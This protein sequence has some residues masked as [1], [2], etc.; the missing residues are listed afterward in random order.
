MKQLH[1][2]IQGRFVVAPFRIFGRG[3]LV[4][5]LGASLLTP[6]AMPVHAAD[7]PDTI[8][9]WLNDINGAQAMGW[10]KAQNARTLDLLGHGPLYKGLYDTSL[11]L[12]Q[13]HDR[14]AMPMQMDGMVYNFWRDEHH[15]RGILRRTTADSFATDH[16][17]WTVALDL[18]ALAAKEKRNWV[19]K[20]I[21][22][23]HSQQNLCLL[24]LSDG[25]E[26][27]STVREF[28]LRTGQFVEGGF[29]LPHAKQDS[30]WLDRDSLLVSYPWSADDLTESSYPYIVK[31][32]KRGQS[33]DQAQTV[34]AG[35]RKDVEVGPEVL[36]DGAGHQ[37]VLIR[38]GLDAFASR[39]F[40]YRDGQTTSLALPLKSSVSALF[41]ARLVVLLDED[42]AV[43][44]QTFTKGSLV[45][46]DPAA[47]SPAP[48]LLL[49]PTA[50]QVIEGA[51]TSHGHLIVTL[52]DNVRGKIAIY[53]PAANGT[54]F[55]HRDLPLPQN[56]SVDLIST[57]EDSPFA[58]ATSS[59]FLT[60]TTL[61]EINSD[62]ASVQKIRTLPSQ[63][64]ASDMTVEQHEARSK[65][66]TD[67]PYFIVH[68]KTMPLD[69]TNPTLLYAY[70]G[71]EVPLF[72]FYS[73][74][75]GNNWLARGGVYVLA[76]IRGGGEFGPAWHDAGLK[77]N[78]Q[79]IYDDF[80]AVAK[81]LMERKVT[82]P[83]HLAIQGG[84]NGGLL[85]GVEFTQH[86]DYWKA[87]DIEVPLLD[88]MNYE[89]MSA[90]A[91][92]VGEYG[93]VSI[94]EQKAFLRSIS[95]LQNL[96]EGVKYPVPFIETTTKDDRVGPVHARRFA[97][98]M[99]EMKLPYYYW[100]QVA[101]G[102]GFGASQKEVAQTQALSYAYLWSQLG[103]TR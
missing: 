96:K 84:S 36:H 27:A 50:G 69:G 12:L 94:P 81:D 89:H 25:G 100:E 91:S 66:G 103:K 39:T 15:L 93:T 24:H 19:Y 78:R 48:Q 83:Q 64:D 9:A 7:L 23:L 58:Y 61:W 1:C 11:K 53:T 31:I 8:P 80:A 41:N 63:F 34:F 38:E 47:K 77:T 37:V 32:L 59:G 30:S 13:T 33:L 71:F 65:D 43:N 35:N 22:C 17:E 74:G 95:P 18:D 57:D 70:G 90:G 2:N 82:S 56:M 4:A 5:L 49:A 86:P 85:M 10:V 44:G 28:D 79:R 87:V 40:L 26:D 99:S 75:I 3:T 51:S 20:G 72:P 97:W 68:R 55:T 42:W 62:L 14:L 76:N 88:M 52:Y 45:L 54:D 21:D 46:V 92:W 67:I 73:A 60:P 102:H 16:P 101:G 29:S 98:R 6:S